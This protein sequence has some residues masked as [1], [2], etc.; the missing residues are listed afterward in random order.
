MANVKKVII[1][2]EKKDEAWNVK[3]RVN[4]K[5]KTIN[6]KTQHFI[7]EKQTRKD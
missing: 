3:I 4:H 5:G 6:L 1:P 2:T 7:G